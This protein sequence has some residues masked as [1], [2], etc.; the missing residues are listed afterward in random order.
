MLPSQFRREETADKASD[1]AAQ[2][3][4]ETLTASFILSLIGG[5]LILAGSGMTGLMGSYPYTNGMMGNLYG[6]YRGMMGGYYGMMGV[7]GYGGWSLVAA[8]IGLISGAVV[9]IGAIMIYTQPNRISTWGLVILV[10]SILSLFGMGG[11]FLGAILGMVGG[12]LALSWRP[13]LGHAST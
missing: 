10:F 4:N 8:A 7:F 3:A 1:L 6:G 9:L 2:P 12:I 5:V 13:Q 11:F